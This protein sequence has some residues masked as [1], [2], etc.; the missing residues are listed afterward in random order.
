VH[1][2]PIKRYFHVASSPKQKV[3]GPSVLSWP[4]F[5]FPTLRCDKYA[6]KMTS[7]F[8]TF[9]FSSWGWGRSYS[10]CL[11]RKV[12]RRLP[13]FRS[14]LM[15]SFSRSQVINYWNIPSSGLLRGVGL[16]DTDVLGL[17]LQGSSSP[18]CCD[19]LE[20]LTLEDGIDMYY[21]NVGIKP[22]YIAEQTRKR[23]HSGKELHCM[24][25]VKAGRKCG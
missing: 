5:V 7:S 2:L 20:C 12:D 4:S 15:S 13:T 21:R 1:C 19:I 16:F 6:G 25:T 3:L 18:S 14:S 23:K 9:P 10:Y 24:Y 17:H 8:A 11:R 22:P